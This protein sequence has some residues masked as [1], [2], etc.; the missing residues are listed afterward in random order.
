V[1]RTTDSAPST[2]ITDPSSNLP[3]LLMATAGRPGERAA[4]DVLTT[5]RFWLA[6]PRF[7]AA[8][9]RSFQ[10]RTWIDWR[11][12]RPFLARTPCSERAH[13]ILL[14]AVELAQVDSGRRL[15]DSPALHGFDSATYHD[16]LRAVGDLIDQHADH[17][18]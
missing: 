13:E 15:R 9:V 12:V 4:I 16:L 8:C 17:Q 3:T 18:P 7:L 5:H 6:H 14:L 10:D 2:V 11:T 1:T